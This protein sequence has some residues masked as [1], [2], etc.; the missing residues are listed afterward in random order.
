M[1]KTNLYTIGLTE[2]LEQE[3]RLYAGLYIA[4]VSVQHKHLYKVITEEGEMTAEVSGKLVFTVQDKSDYPTV[5][6]WVMVDRTCDTAGHLIINVILQRSSMLERKAAGTAQ[7]RQLIAANIDTIFICMSLNNDFNLRR[8]E[9]YLAIAWDSMAIPVIILTK[10]DLCPNLSEKLSELRPTAPGVD[11][12]V[13]SSLSKEGYVEISKYIDVGKTVAFIGSSGVGKSTLINRLAG[14]E[15]FVT[16]EIDQYDKGRHTTTQRQLIVLPMGG[17][18]IDTPGMRELQL[19]TAD[20]SKAFADIEQLAQN[21]RFDDCSHQNE[22]GCAIKTAIQT[23]TL[24]IERLISYQ[25]LQAELTYQGMSSRQLE[26]VK[27][28]RMFGS[29]GGM[30]EA[31]RSIKEKNKRR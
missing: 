4:R 31:S 13:T 5:G 15:V 2:L 8:L 25:K 28:K 26:Q 9:R 17:V 12:L 18:V 24:L 30:K 22:P 10:A 1:S 7:E 20:L 19:E 29:L 27:A 23:G 11:I 3:S 21:C 16:K 6:D 14:T